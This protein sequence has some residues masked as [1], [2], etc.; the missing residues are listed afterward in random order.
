MTPA[1]YLIPA[2]L[3][4]AAPDA[5][6][7]AAAETVRRLRDFVAENPKTAR[8]FLSALGMP[9]ALRDLNIARLDEHT[10]AT[11]VAV[12]LAPLR[13][14]RPLGLLS[15]A[16]CPGVADPGA[17]LVRLAHGEGFRVAPLIGPSSILL[18][19]MASGLGGQCFAFC[20]YLPRERDARK[21]RIRELELRSRSE[22]Q[23]QI[24][25]ETPYRNRALLAALL[26][27]CR[28]ETRLCVASGLTTPGETIVARP[29]AEWRRRPHDPG[30]EPAVFLL[31]G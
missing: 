3:G 29:V 31:L 12:L 20:G 13:A 10:A 8:A 1:L 30:E 19:L 22:R 27:V 21:R 9:C 16:G 28:P 4:G 17:E 6:P 11:G 26:E 18:A 15:E 24:F 25:I 23:T 2:P 5:L 7:A 14:G